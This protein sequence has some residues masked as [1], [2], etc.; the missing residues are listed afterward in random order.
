MNVPLGMEAVSTT[1]ST[2]VG[3]ITALVTMDMI[4]LMELI[5]QVST[6]SLGFTAC[7]TCHLAQRFKSHIV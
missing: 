3:V 6:S 5:V 1:V 2:L 7:F 4:L